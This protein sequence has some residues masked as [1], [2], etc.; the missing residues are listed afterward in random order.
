MSRRFFTETGLLKLSLDWV[1]QYIN[2]NKQ[3]QFREIFRKQ[4][5]YLLFSLL[6]IVHRNLYSDNLIYFFI[7]KY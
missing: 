4:D 2:T 7:F 5:R 1:P 3:E 6:K